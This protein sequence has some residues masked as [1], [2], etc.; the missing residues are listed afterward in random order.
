VTL[1]SAQ[2]KFRW[3]KNGENKA[4][5]AGIQEDTLS[6]APINWKLAPIMLM[7]LLMIASFTAADQK[8]APDAKSPSAS[9]TASAQL[10][11][12]WHSESSHKDFRVEVAKDAFRAEWVNLPPTAAKQGAY[13]HTE[14]R[15]TGDKWVGTSSVY[16]A[17][18]ISKD[19]A[20]KTTKMCHLTIRFEVDSITPEKITF[21]SEAMRNFDPTKCQLLQTAWEEFSWVPKK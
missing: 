15:R 19:P 10:P 18:A 13:I 14:C 6:L 12:I 16:Q 8:P 11:K 21:H 3:Q 9:K 2:K 20:V 5:E 7:A 4:F 17:A 1:A